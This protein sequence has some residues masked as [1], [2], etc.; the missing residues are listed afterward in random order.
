[1][2]TA[3]TK[4]AAVETVRKWLRDGTLALPVHERLRRELLLFEE[5]ITPTGQFSFSGKHDDH[6][7]LLVTCA[8]AAA[9]GSLPRIPRF[10][11]G[12]SSHRYAPTPPRAPLHDP[13]GCGVRLDP[14]LG[15]G[16]G[17]GGVDAGVLTEF[18]NHRFTGGR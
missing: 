9:R 15:G 8:M 17:F 11:G 1:V 4:P 18:R 6:V 12:G 3:Q 14:E 10:P 2:W 13:W 16:G 5:R 7:S